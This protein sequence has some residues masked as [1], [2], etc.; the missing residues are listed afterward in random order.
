MNLFTPAEFTE[1]YTANS[2]YKVEKPTLKLILLAVLAGLIV[3]FGAMTSNT[4][5]FAISN[6]SI[7]RLISALIFPFGLG[8]V[9]ICGAELF[10]GNIMI[11]M[12]VLDKR[13]SVFY[14]LRNWTIVYFGNFAGALILAA[15]AAFYGQMDFGGGDLAVYSVKVAVAKSSLPFAN[16]FVLGI[17]CNLLVCL[18]VLLSMSAKDSTGKIVG[19][20]LPT[21][22]FVLGGFEH[23][24]ANMYYIPA[25]IF[26][27]S[28]ADTL[29]RVVQA[30]MDISRLNW[31]NFIFANLLPVTLGNIIGGL[32]I[33]Y[34]FWRTQ[35]RE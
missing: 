34:I 2:K 4:A 14:M 23:C 19:A 25:G 10:T 29:E 7:A 20:Y 30:G 31:G 33:S 3:G 8:T 28:K 6:Y 27:L 12:S 17:M 5:V 11:T 9:M 1:L 15:A 22:F 24:I 32:V 13:N 18:A 21:A 35:I 26:A 16:A